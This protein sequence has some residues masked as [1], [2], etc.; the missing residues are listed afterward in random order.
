M[1][2]LDSHIKRG[3]S[4]R[5]GPSPGT[6]SIIDPL[7]NSGHSPEVNDGD[8]WDDWYLLGGCAAVVVWAVSFGALILVFVAVGSGDGED[9]GLLFALSALAAFG[10]FGLMMLVAWLIEHRRGRH[11]V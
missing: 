9:V 6:R 7:T 8:K 10:V 3:R 4:H 1:W 11:E 2:I 5:N